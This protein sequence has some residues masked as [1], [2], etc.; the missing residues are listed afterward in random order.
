MEPGASVFAGA[1]IVEIPMPISAVSSSSP[2]AT[3]NPKVIT[4][5]TAATPM[6]MTSVAPVSGTALSASLG[7]GVTGCQ[8]PRAGRT[9]VWVPGG[10]GL[11]CAG[12]ADQAGRGA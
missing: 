1:V 10:P 6:P 9:T 7:G 4:S 5:T 2:A 11:L 3:S 8:A 12:Q